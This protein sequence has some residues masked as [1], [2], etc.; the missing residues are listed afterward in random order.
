MLKMK[1]WVQ[2]SSISMAASSRGIE[3]MGDA[4]EELGEAGL[5]SFA[6]PGVGRTELPSF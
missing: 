2:V 6:L 3:A 1:R 5:R 4:G